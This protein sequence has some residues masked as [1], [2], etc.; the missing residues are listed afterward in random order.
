MA[1]SRVFSA[2]Q[3]HGECGCSSSTR[4]CFYSIM[5]TSALKP[6]THPLGYVEA[7]A[8][9]GPESP[10]ALG[11]LFFFK[12]RARVPLGG[13]GV[14]SAMGCLSFG[15]SVGL[16]SQT[17]GTCTPDS[18]RAATRPRNYNTPP[19]NAHSSSK[20][21]A[22]SAKDVHTRAIGATGWCAR[23]LMRRGGVGECG[24]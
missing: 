21:E 8:A 17:L 1:T 6:G 24:D 14:A 13:T 9:A 12:G 16:G 15:V 3:W 11:A 2:G 23:H 4:P 20:P 5:N 19:P 18:Q 10:G 7:L 22:N